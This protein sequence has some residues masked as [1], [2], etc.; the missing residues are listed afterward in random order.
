MDNF[1]QA[2]KDFTNYFDTITTRYNNFKYVLELQLDLSVKEK[3]TII[4]I[5]NMSRGTNIFYT[6]LQNLE[7]KEKIPEGD[8]QKLFVLSV[9]WP[10]NI[11]VEKFK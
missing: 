8:A 9:D 5:H 4:E 7:R 6:H 2:A 1:L 10:K 11:M 3:N